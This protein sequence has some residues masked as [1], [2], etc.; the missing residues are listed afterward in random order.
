MQP[1]KVNATEGNNHNFAR[2]S[3]TE[4]FLYVTSLVGVVSVPLVEGNNQ[5]FSRGSTTELYLLQNQS[6]ILLVLHNVKALPEGVQ[7]LYSK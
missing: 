1:I 4:L 5:I 7:Q 3:P 2:G 6:H